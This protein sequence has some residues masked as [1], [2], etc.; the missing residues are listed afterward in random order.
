MME[1]ADIIRILLL[2]A[3]IMVLAIQQSGIIEESL[4]NAGHQSA[5]ARLPHYRNMLD[6][7]RRNHIRFSVKAASNSFLFLSEKL[8]NTIDYNNDH[9]YA[10]IALGGWGNSKSIIYRGTMFGESGAVSTPGILDGTAFKNFWASWNNGVIKVG[11]GFIIG[12]NVIMEK[13][14]PLTTHIK[15][16]AL[17]NAYGSSG[18]WKL[19]PGI[20][21]INTNAHLSLKICDWLRDFESKGLKF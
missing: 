21:I 11:S 4:P 10:E 7:T 2:F 16:L 13:W 15:Y 3:P 17:L 1:R 6:I 14:Y 18:N 5:G 8:V 12:D 19:Y 9:G 20:T